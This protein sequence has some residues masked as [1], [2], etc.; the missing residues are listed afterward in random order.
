MQVNRLIDINQDLH[1]AIDRNACYIA[2]LET[3]I[4]CNWRSFL[5]KV[6]CDFLRTGF[7][8]KD[9]DGEEPL[10]IEEHF[11]GAPES[12]C[13]RCACRAECQPE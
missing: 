10:D 8:V 5:L 12:T 1:L 4:S 11:A 9:L 3:V 13:Q 2:Q 7:K 6:R